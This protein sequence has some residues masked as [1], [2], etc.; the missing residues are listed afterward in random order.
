MLDRCSCDRE[1]QTSALIWLM[2]R[3]LGK[4]ARDLPLSITPR[5]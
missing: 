2:R 4:L 3:E 1:K 5:L